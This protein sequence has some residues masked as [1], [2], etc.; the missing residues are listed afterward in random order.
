MSQQIKAALILG[1]VGDRP[2]E[3][4]RQFPGMTL[5]PKKGPVKTPYANIYYYE[6]SGCELNFYLVER[7]RATGKLMHPNNLRMTAPALMYFLTQ[8][9]KVNLVVST[10][11]IGAAN[12]NNF[13]EGELSPGKIIVPND[14]MDLSGEVTTFSCGP[15]VEINC[16]AGAHV[17]SG[18]CTICPSLRAFLG[19]TDVLLGR[20]VLS[21]TRG[22]RFETTAEKVILHQLGADFF[23][24]HTTKRD[25][26]LCQELQ[27]V[28]FLPLL[29]VTNMVFENPDDTGH[30]VD[31]QAKK[32]FPFVME[33]FFRILR[34]LKEQPLS[35][36]CHKRP[37]TFDHLTLKFD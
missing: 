13:R 6:A 37:N 31:L 29:H 36:D 12:G 16:L 1:T 5:S 30:D 14:F 4:F 8:A 19:G 9:M 33:A 10:G 24:M 32:N 26:E 18:T 28:H 7:H 17:P 11:A 21:C 3:L 34:K 20:G 27:G 25:W 2:H 35:C 15:N 22:P 23:G